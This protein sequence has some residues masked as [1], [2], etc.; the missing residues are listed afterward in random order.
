MNRKRLGVYKTIERDFKLSVRTYR[1][2]KNGRKVLTRVFDFIQ[3]IR[4]SGTI[5]VMLATNP[6]IVGRFS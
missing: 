6:I 3:L 1:Q 2:K 5:K 4:S